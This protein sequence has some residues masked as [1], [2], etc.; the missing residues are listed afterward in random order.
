[1]TASL[2]SLIALEK[3]TIAARRGAEAELAAT[4]RALRAAED[5]LATLEAVWLA[6]PSLGEGIDAAALA[7]WT[8]AH[9][10]A[11][12]DGLQALAEARGARRE[13]KARARVAIARADAAG[14]LVAAAKVEA[15]R[16][17]ERRAETPPRRPA[18]LFR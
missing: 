11:R 15:R 14:E 17:E 3:A 18:S 5:R 12:Q 7:R 6:Q 4:G 16:A 9:D 1:M 13:A 10:S 8:D 2:K